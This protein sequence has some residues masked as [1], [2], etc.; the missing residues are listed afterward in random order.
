MSK[1][2]IS[3]PKGTKSVDHLLRKQLIRARAANGE[4]KRAVEIEVA[5]MTATDV[6]AR[7]AALVTSDEDAQRAAEG[8]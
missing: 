6:A 3:M 7:L 1:K 5:A 2:S 8:E 4:D